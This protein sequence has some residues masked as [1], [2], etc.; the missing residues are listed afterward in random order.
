MG[1]QGRR[2]DMEKQFKSNNIQC[3]GSSTFKKPKCPKCGRYHIGFCMEG[4]GACYNCGK[5]GHFARDYRVQVPEPKK[6]PARVFTL[7][8]AQTESSP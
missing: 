8:Q 2:F 1:G 4:L 6:V 3:L 7:T 5:M